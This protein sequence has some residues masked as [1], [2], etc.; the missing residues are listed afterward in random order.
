MT[1]LNPYRKPNP[2]ELLGVPHGFQAIEP[3]KWLQFELQR[4]GF[5]FGR[6]DGMFQRKTQKAVHEAQRA[7]HLHVDGFVTRE[8]L[9][10]LEGEPLG[11]S[12]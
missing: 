9:D 7:L 10:R 2:R 8:L 12:G 1:S 5:Y 4:H 3:V 6:I 11:V